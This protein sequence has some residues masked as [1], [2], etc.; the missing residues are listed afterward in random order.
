MVG[1]RPCSESAM[2]RDA[3]QTLKRRQLQLS[4]LSSV[5]GS[6]NEDPHEPML[7]LDSL[8]LP[9][10]NCPIEMLQV[11]T[12]TVVVRRPEWWCGSHFLGGR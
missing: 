11:L 6:E 1:L 9:G 5:E 3:H 8:V 7:E 2:V 4:P 12:P 10:D